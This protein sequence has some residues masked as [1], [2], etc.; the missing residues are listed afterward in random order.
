MDAVLRTTIPMNSTSISTRTTTSLPSFSF[1]VFS[2]L[3]VVFVWTTAILAWWMVRQWTWS[4]TGRTTISDR[5]PHAVHSHGRRLAESQRHRPVQ[6][7]SA[8]PV[9]DWHGLPIVDTGAIMSPGW[10]STPDWCHYKDQGS[11]DAEALYLLDWLF[12]Q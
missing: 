11:S 6:H 12:S 8:H 4:C 2:Y 7:H 1:S 3:F 5:R 10:D 9:C